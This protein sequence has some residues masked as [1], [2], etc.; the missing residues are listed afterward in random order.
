MFFPR[1]NKILETTE[2][3]LE[4]YFKIIKLRK[5][6]ANPNMKKWNQPSTGDVWTVNT[7]IFNFFLNKLQND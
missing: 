1:Q 6:S 5:N 7:K 3:H 2:K 4:K